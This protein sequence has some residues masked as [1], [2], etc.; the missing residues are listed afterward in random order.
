M[1]QFVIR[2]QGLSSSYSYY[3]ACSWQMLIYNLF[4]MI[5]LSKKGFGVALSRLTN[6]CWTGMVQT[7]WE[8]VKGQ[9]GVGIFHS[10]ISGNKVP[11]MLST[12]GGTK[13]EEEKS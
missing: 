8:Y 4:S 9:V 11:E 13:E 12:M 1:H 2:E 5:T 3:L 6:T 10:G 7:L